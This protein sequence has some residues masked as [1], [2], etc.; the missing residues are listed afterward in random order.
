MWFVVCSSINCLLTD[1]LING[2]FIDTHSNETIL[3][4]SEPNQNTSA[5]EMGANVNSTQNTLEQ[6]LMA[7]ESRP[8][9]DDH[10]H[11]RVKRLH[12][13]RPLFVYRQEQV[14]RR[15]IIENRKFRNRNSQR[16][17]DRQ[18]STPCPCHNCRRY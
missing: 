7:A 3:N 6:M 4:E 16:R 12:V 9:P 13:F 17:R 14:Q 5:L 18:F 15:L 11:K 1:S 10:R 8:P 2:K